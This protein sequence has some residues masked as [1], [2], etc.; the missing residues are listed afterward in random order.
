MSTNLFS[1]DKEYFTQIYNQ[2][3]DMVYR[4]CYSFLKNEAEAKDATQE[5]FIKLWNYNKY[6]EDEKHIK[7]WLIVTSSN[8]CKN[9]LKHWWWKRES[10]E[11][12]SIV[13]G[14]SINHRDETLE[15]VLALPEKYKVP[16][17]LYYYEGY[18]SR[19]IAQLMKKPE[20]TVRTYLQ[21]AKKLLFQEVNNG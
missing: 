9:I 19:E 20:S 7:A 5:V 10:I 8:H 1:T 17:Y 4:L 3:I 12:S 21:K 11:D 15:L 2:H 16:V 14:A 13:E 18:N 6:F